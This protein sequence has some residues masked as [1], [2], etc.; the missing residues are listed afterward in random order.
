MQTGDI[1]KAALRSPSQQSR[2]AVSC[3]ACLKIRQ[4]VSTIL[5]RLD[6]WLAPS[7]RGIASTFP[8]YTS[9]ASADARQA[10]YPEVSKMIQYVISAAVLLAP[11]CLGNA[12]DLLSIPEPS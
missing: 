2:T 6:C 8:T 5:Q 3:F 12:L 10:Y 7:A 1:R 4:A 9:T 11:R